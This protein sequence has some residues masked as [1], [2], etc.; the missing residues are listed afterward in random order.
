MHLFDVDFSLGKPSDAFLSVVQPNGRVA[1]VTGRSDQLR[2]TGLAVD[3]P[4]G[5][6]AIDVVV[7][8]TLRNTSDFYVNI[9]AFV[10]EYNGGFTIPPILFIHIG[11]LYPFLGEGT[12]TT[13]EP[14]TPTTTADPT[15]DDVYVFALIVN[16]QE[17][18]SSPDGLE[19][20]QERIVALGA[21]YVNPSLNDTSLCFRFSPAM[22][23]R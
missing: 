15:D 10:G 4:G 5:R 14:T 23:C 9:N 8:N 21:A 2:G 3:A 6:N 11:N 19:E 13:E 18:Y 22:T 20:L 1:I 16:E 17:F 7:Q 12:L